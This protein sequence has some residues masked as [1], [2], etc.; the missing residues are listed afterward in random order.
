MSQMSSTCARVCQLRPYYI[1][2]KYVCM[3]HNI[4]WCVPS[5]VLW[6]C[7]G[8][9]PPNLSHN[10]PWFP[11]LPTSLSAFRDSYFY[12]SSFYLSLFKQCSSGCII[13]GN[14][15]FMDSKVNIKKNDEIDIPVVILWSNT[16][17][18]PKWDI[19][20]QMIT[21]SWSYQWW[22]SIWYLCGKSAWYLIACHYSPIWWHSD[23]LYR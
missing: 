3:T 13:W 19:I 15:I 9:S 2:V 10:T 21:D 12:L 4:F 11:Q 17:S 23:Y 22:R 6:A 8:S 5:C 18:C 1:H 7:S 20:T 16:Q 14:V